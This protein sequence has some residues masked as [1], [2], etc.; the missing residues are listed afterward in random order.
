MIVRQQE[1]VENGQIAIVLINGSDAVCKEFRRV[2]SGIMLI[3]RNPNYEPMVFT[4]DEV[5]N[6]PV[7]VIGRV[8]EVRR[9]L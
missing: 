1:E 6:K 5:E 9:E 3:S 7:R 4:Q 8:V 2:S